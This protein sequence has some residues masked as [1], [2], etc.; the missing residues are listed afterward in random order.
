MD[1]GCAGC[2]S[3]TQDVTPHYARLFPTPELTSGASVLGHSRLG[4]GYARIGQAS[5]WVM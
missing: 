2:F 1:S 3:D 4:T 5:L